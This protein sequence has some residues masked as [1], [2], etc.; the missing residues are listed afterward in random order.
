M[1]QT[2][3]DKLF[4]E[5]LTTGNVVIYMD[6]ILTAMAGTL[7][8]HKQEVHNVLQKLKDNDLYLKPE[9]CQF[10]QKEMEYLGVIVGNGWVK[11]DLVKVQGISK[12]PT[13]TTVRELHSFLGFG[14]YYK[15]FITNYS[16][17][18]CPLHKLTKK[19]IQWHWDQPQQVAFE[20][21][22]WAFTSY[23]VLQNLDPDKCYTCIL[24]TDTLAYAISTTL[25]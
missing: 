2:I 22:F 16:Q 25:S 20:M 15:D 18:A 11:M 21:L 19:T 8:V 23:P 12:W 9:K 17:I 7:N 14:N 3:I 1:F 13:P 24:D 5:K 6:N 4:K 10:H